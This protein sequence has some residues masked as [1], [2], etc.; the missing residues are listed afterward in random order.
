MKQL[1]NYQAAQLIYKYEQ[2]LN[3]FERILGNKKYVEAIGRSEIDTYKIK[4]S[5][6][7][8]LDSR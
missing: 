2:V 4:R 6:E 7:K 1:R 8:E 3:H 5:S